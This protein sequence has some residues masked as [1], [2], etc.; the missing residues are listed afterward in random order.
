MTMDD[1]IS[2]QR[3]MFNKNTNDP[4]RLEGLPPGTTPVGMELFRATSP[5]D[6]RPD[7]VQDLSDLKYNKYPRPT[8]SPIP[9][10]GLPGRAISKVAQCLDDRLIAMAPGKEGY[11]CAKP[12]PEKIPL[13]TI[14]IL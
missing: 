10:L 13:S 14:L 6:F 12:A 1:L 5:V 11:Y 7:N 9:N 3:Q 8:Y 4:R 2:K